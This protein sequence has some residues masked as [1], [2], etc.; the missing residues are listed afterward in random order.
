MATAQLLAA[1]HALRSQL[2][3]IDDSIAEAHEAL[4]RVETEAGIVREDGSSEAD[5]IG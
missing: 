3:T 5:E 1:V 2:K 4:D